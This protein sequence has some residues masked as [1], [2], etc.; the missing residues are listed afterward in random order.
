MNAR[1][2]TSL[3]LLSAS[4]ALTGCDSIKSYFAPATGG[5]PTGA[6]PAEQKV[7]KY[8]AAQADLAKHPFDRELILYDDNNK[9]LAAAAK[10]K[11]TLKDPLTWYYN[12]T[13]PVSSAILRLK[14]AT[15]IPA[16]LGPLDAAAAKLTASLETLNPTIKDMDVYI[17]SHQIDTDNGAKAKTFDPIYR[18]QMR[19]AQDAETAFSQ[20]LSAR[21]LA[22]DKAKLAAMKPDSLDYAINNTLIATRNAVDKLD[23][24]TINPDPKFREA[25]IAAFAA[26]IDPIETA[27]QGLT[28]AI[29][30][31]PGFT[32]IDDCKSYNAKT[33]HLVATGRDA[34]KDPFGRVLHENKSQ[35]FVGEYNGTIPDLNR[36]M[37][38]IH[39][40]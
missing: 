12:P 30:A 2:A 11:K 38:H 7:S 15:A 17:N 27:N 35:A 21:S 26:S 25:A 18:T 19:A 13:S 37:A 31:A 6:T 8:A 34:A 3:L 23:D 9:E 10:S 29:A 20:A 4:V 14:E 36:C 5:G 22:D 1:R 16:D 28:K 40:H 39:E 33:T 32:K 24:T